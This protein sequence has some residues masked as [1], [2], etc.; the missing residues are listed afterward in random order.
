MFH[1]V[2]DDTTGGVHAVEIHADD[3]S[4]RT[5]GDVKKTAATLLKP[6]HVP[7]IMAA[8]DCLEPLAVGMSAM[9]G[10]HVVSSDHEMQHHVTA[11]CC[12]MLRPTQSQESVGFQQRQGL[13]R[14]V[15]TTRRVV[16]H[17]MKHVPQLSPCAPI[18]LVTPLQVYHGMVSR[19]A[20]AGPGIGQRLAG[21]E[22]R[23]H[24]RHDHGGSEGLH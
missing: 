10:P 18:S 9:C 4:A 1:H 2:T 14:L 5:C 12:G 17:M 24:G 11:R 20:A 3:A 15:S 7:Y 21:R 6:E 19:G 16:R 22:S 8:H 23:R 13:P